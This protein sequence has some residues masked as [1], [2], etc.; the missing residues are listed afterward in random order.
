MGFGYSFK[1]LAWGNGYAR[2]TVKSII[3]FV[4][5]Q[6]IKKFVADCAAE[7]TGLDNVLS[8]CG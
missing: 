7:N 4:I 5:S 8:K 6:V 2:E 1:K 3:K